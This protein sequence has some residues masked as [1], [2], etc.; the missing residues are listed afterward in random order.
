MGR[1]SL[2]HF[3]CTNLLKILLALYIWG[4]KTVSRQKENHTLKDKEEKKNQ[5]KREK[6]NKEKFN[7]EMK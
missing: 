5:P 2:H 3:K 1:I 6:N 7:W 4:K